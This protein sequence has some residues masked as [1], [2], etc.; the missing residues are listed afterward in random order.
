M[1]HLKNTA[2]YARR[3]RADLLIEEGGRTGE[4]LK[5]FIR[6]ERGE[7]A[8]ITVD[9]FLE[10]E[11]TWD[12]IRREA[13]RQALNES[14]PPDVTISEDDVFYLHR[15]KDAFDVYFLA[16][17][18]QEDKGRVTITFEQVARPELWDP[19][20]GETEPI[21][22]YRVRDGRLEI[23]LDF[24]PNEA[25]VVVLK[26]DADVPHVTDTNLCV[27]QV[28]TDAVV[29]F[30]GAA[31]K[32]VFARVATGGDEVEVRGESKSPRHPIRLP[33]RYRFE[34]E[35]DNVLVIGR[36]KMSLED[37]VD[38]AAACMQPGYDDSAWLD[39]EQGAWEPQLP[40][41]RD[42]EV[43]PVALWYRTHFEIADLPS[44]V[45]LM[46]DGFAG[47][48]YRLFVNGSEVEDKGVR[49]WL[50]A[51][52]KEVNV[53]PFV[54]QGR[55]T[56][57]VRLEVTRRTDGL[58]DLLKI[59]GDFSVYGSE[60]SGF[61]IAAR[62]TDVIVGSWTNQG[63]P[64]Y[65]GTGV[66]RTELDVPAEYLDGGRLYLEADCGEDVLEV[67]VNDGEPRV[68]VWYP[69]R[70]D[71]TDDLHQGLNTIEIRVTNTLINILEGVQKASGLFA[72]PRI[73]H[74]HRYELVRK[75][76]GAG[77]A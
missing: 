52:I 15:V 59:V 30:S 76:E 25:H 77:H 43:Y 53:L 71:V 20:T 44:D 35:Q 69:Y 28:S 51:E 61:R 21:N 1:F 48:S 70:L 29:G 37:A 9:Q 66:Y 19:N 4:Q 36:W 2:L 27:E 7:N 41:E 13:L 18:T 63:Y 22:V 40:H 56:V 42:D 65:S 5:A 47:S 50:D 6:E 34:P 55:N 17:I 73:V 14:A 64:F 67:R 46:I 68:A 33:D 10:E 75:P 57:A 26:G 3:I 38:D 11:A 45:R 58:L 54:R 24:P 8:S 16:N 12:R 31:V 49:S 32:E 23:E 39:V 72:P 74:E 60:T 62:N